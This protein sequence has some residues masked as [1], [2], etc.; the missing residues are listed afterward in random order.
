MTFNATC[1]T[2]DLSQP[3]TYSQFFTSHTRDLL[4]NYYVAK[5]RNIISVNYFLLIFLKKYIILNNFFLLMAI[6]IYI[7]SMHSLN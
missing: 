5:Y 6:L 2:S 4:I 7:I 3:V 1:F